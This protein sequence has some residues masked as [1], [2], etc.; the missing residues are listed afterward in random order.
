MMK[1]REKQKKGRTGNSI[2]L[3]NKPRNPIQHR[4]RRARPHCLLQQCHKKHAGCHV[5]QTDRRSK[6]IPINTLNATAVPLHSQ[7][8]APR[9]RSC[10]ALAACCRIICRTTLQHFLACKSAPA[11]SSKMPEHSSSDADSGAAPG[12]FLKHAK[13][14]LYAPKPLPQ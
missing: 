8:P 2:E 5:R 13:T 6:C 9:L 10:S 11:A 4:T 7:P 3:H 14:G 1:T 12:N